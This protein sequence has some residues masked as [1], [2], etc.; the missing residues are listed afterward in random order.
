MSH[1]TQR[2]AIGV[3][4]HAADARAAIQDL[5]RTGFLEEEI[6]VAAREVQRADVG[7]LDRTTPEGSQVEEGAV[8]GL[9][10]G[11]GLG[12]LWGV[13]VV[14]GLLPAVGPAIAGGT[15]AAILS[16]AAAGAA[17]AG[18]A[19][20][21]IGAGIPEDEASYYE[22]EFHAGRIILSVRAG[23]RYEEAKSILA[24]HGG[25]DA[26]AQEPTR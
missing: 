14:A 25:Y 1:Q 3:F 18:V 10:A 9:A 4:Q 12:A 19:G 22:G 11:A 13:A 26:N 5:R 6:G 23:D 7:V 21:L 8:T 2:T 17:A 24:R 16:S 15:L 20:A